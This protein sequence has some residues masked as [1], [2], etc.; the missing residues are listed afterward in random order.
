MLISKKWLQ[1]Y[2]PDIQGISDEEIARKLTIGIAEVEEIRHLGAG[3]EKVVVGE[4]LEVTKHPQADKL[5]VTKVDVGAQTGPLQIVCGAPNVS[6]GIK[7]AVCLPGGKAIDPTTGQSFEIKV[8]KLRGIESQGMIMSAAELGISDEH[9]GIL[10]LA[11]GTKV[12]EEFDDFVKDTIFEIENKSL[13][14]RGDCFSHLGIA[15]EISALLNIDLQQEDVNFDPVQTET[16]SLELSIETPKS[17]QFS[18]ITLKNVQVGSSPLWLQVLLSSIGV[19]SV[20]NVVDI[21]NYVMHA[22]GQPLHAYDYDKVA[23]NRLIVR[24]SRS[25]EKMTAI[26]HKE[27]SLSGGDILI[28]DTKQ[29]HGIAGLM[30]A[31]GSEVST[32]TTNI[33]LEAAQFDPEQVLKSSRYLAL[34]SEAGIR[35]SKGVDPEGVQ[36]GLKIALNLLIDLCQADIAS[37]ILSVKSE[38]L[39]DKPRVIEFDLQEIPRVTGVSFDT[40]SA[41]IYLERLGIKVLNRSGI[42]SRA[43]MLTVPQIAQLEIPSYRSDLRIHQD[44]VEEVARVHGYDNIEP[45]LPTARLTASRLSAIGSFNRQVADLATRLG[46]TEL[47]T[48]SFISKQLHELFGLDKYKSLEV[49]NAIS[50]ELNFVRPSLVPS[51][52]ESA[53]KNLNYFSEVKVFELGRVADAKSYTEEGLPV[54]DFHLS[55][56]SSYAQEADSKDGVGNLEWYLDRK[57]DIEELLENLRIPE[58]SYRWADLDSGTSHLHKALHPYRSSA[59]LLGDQLLGVFG[60]IHPEIIM[61]AGG[62]DRMV[63][64]EMNLQKL[65]SSSLPGKRGFKLIAALPSVQR[66]VSYWINSNTKLGEVLSFAKEIST[67]G[68]A[69]SSVRIDVILTDEY[70]DAQKGRSATFTIKITPLED[71]LTDQQANEISTRI[72]NQ[73]TSKFRLTSRSE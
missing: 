37:E 49:Q 53:L 39:A 3:V 56:L 33:I 60:E 62:K 51:L 26:D 25:G 64:F 50:P 35:F 18:A 19:R 17:L 31:E 30:G 45:K 48:Y 68:N 34:R 32:E 42:N 24:E 47:R 6:A 66:D 65:L 4:V 36:R 10:I 2:L 70:F 16:L 44:I 9:D 14:H 8:A 20:N 23:G 46:Y 28:T 38:Q 27:Y 61:E 43:N 29:I 55:M 11:D 58:G 73:I 22:T 52:F 13:T 71:T 41:L 57:A 7:V 72:A 12:G 40:E 5:N 67:T 63:V 59:L 21:T 15:R 69:S 54:Q 1:K